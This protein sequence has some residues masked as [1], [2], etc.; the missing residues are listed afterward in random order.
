M[1][2]MS[3]FICGRLSRGPTPSY[4]PAVLRPALLAGLAAAL[5]FSGGCVPLSYLCPEQPTVG[6]PCKVAL[7]LQ[8]GLVETQD[9]VNA[10]APLRGLAGRMFLFQDTV[11]PKPIVCEGELIVDL[12]DDRPMMTGGQPVRLERWVFADPILKQLIRKDAQGWG[13]TLFLP[14][15][16]TYRPDITQIHL[17]AAFAPKGSAMPLFESSPSIALGP[18]QFPMMPGLA[19]GAA[20]KMPPGASAINPALLQTGAQ[21]PAAVAPA[22]FPPP[23]P[24]PVP[25]NSWTTGRVATDGNV[26][27]PAPPPPLSVTTIPVT[28]PA[29]SSAMPTARPA[30]LPA[31]PMPVPTSGLPPQ[32]N[33]T[34]MAK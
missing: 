26:Q 16:K 27:P 31:T 18:S 21:Q 22:T 6:M 9:S 30:A 2:V 34:G 13:Y 24:Q 19:Q 28:G 20:P 1:S 8:P 29:L 17:L 10:G 14:W 5:V 7:S 11:T 33:W 23:T 32:S 12:Y 3:Q 25:A 4:S 15:V